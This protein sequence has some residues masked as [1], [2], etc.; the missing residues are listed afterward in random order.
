MKI[1]L[2][3]T[4]PEHMDACKRTGLHGTNAPNFKPTAGD[5]VVTY[6]TEVK[7]IASVSVLSEVF[8]DSSLDSL[9]SESYS[10]LFRLS[11]IQ[12]LSSPLPVVW[13]RAPGRG[14]YCGRYDLNPP[15]GPQEL[16]PLQFA[17]ILEDIQAQEV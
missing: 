4:K 7:Q 1:W 15:V 10:L 6:L 12:E 9:W 3:P 13:S 5:L 11:P 17:L 16:S 14:T 8:A 2:I